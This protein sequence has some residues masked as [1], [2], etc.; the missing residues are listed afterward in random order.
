MHWH[1]Q[2]YSIFERACKPIDMIAGI[3]DRHTGITNSH[4][5][6][7][8][9]N[10]REHLPFLFFSFVNLK[11]TLTE[12]TQKGN[13]SA[14][15]MQALLWKLICSFI[16]TDRAALKDV[17]CQQNTGFLSGLDKAWETNT[18]LCAQD[19]WGPCVF[20]PCVVSSWSREG[21]ME[22]RLDE[23]SKARRDE[24]R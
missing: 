6:H 8:D 10:N 20:E 16:F 21:A 3:A 24:Q 11:S 5:H 2:M 23:R 13:K 9:F 18:F 22:A 17:R 19:S 14:T 12:D 4:L 1:H 15:S 7:V